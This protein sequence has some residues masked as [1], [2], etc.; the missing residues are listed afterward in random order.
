M[1]LDAMRIKKRDSL[2]TASLTQVY[3]NPPYLIGFYSF[4]LAE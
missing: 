1:K 4:E 3:R 2:I